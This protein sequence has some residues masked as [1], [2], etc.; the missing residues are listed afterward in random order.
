MADNFMPAR[1]F[2]DQQI[3]D[4]FNQILPL[5]Y[6]IVS[7]NAAR[8]GYIPHRDII[9]ALMA[10]GPQ[11]GEA[12]QSAGYQGYD[13]TWVAQYIRPGM[14]SA[15]NW[16]AIQ[17][18]ARSFYMHPNTDWEKSA[19]GLMDQYQ[20]GGVGTWE[21]DRMKMINDI[22]NM[23]L[24]QGMTVN[25]ATGQ[26]GWTLGRILGGI[27]DWSAMQLSQAWQQLQQTIEEFE[28]KID[29]LSLRFPVAP[30]TP[31]GTSGGAK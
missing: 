23:E 18:Y 7:G 3:A 28:R 27:G 17:D 20:F 6:D 15:A 5:I 1:S 11:L 31:D 8:K 21:T 10:Y 16:S 19:L 4:Q 22:L 12:L 14:Q 9:N 29:E 25:P 2:T 24:F 13:P 26:S 30:R